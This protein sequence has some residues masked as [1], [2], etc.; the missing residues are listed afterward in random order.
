M[1]KAW[2]KN[3]LLKGLELYKNNQFLMLSVTIIFTFLIIIIII[4]NEFYNEFYNKL[5][6]ARYK[7]LG[8]PFMTNREVI[9]MAVPR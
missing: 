5:L 8:G 7:S 6:L 4:I 1:E 9:R 2:A 3:I